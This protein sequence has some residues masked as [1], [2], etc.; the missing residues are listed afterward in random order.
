MLTFVAD[1]VSWALAAFWPSVVA[2]LAVG[3][4]SARFSASLRPVFAVAV[5]ACFI[6]YL[7]LSLHQALDPTNNRLVRDAVAF[8]T[9]GVI[10]PGA[11]YGA[12]LLC[13]PRVA[14]VRATAPVVLGLIPILASPLA[15]LLVHCSSGDCL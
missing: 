7:A 10:S 9:I 8:V 3:L 1:S 11:A 13:R 15:L 6:A 4:S 5:G 2:V 14:W 12:A